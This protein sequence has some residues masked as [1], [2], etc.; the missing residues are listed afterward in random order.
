MPRSPEGQKKIGLDLYGADLDSY[1]ETQTHA[2]VAAL[3]KEGVKF[4]DV[5]IAWWGS[6]HNIASDLKK[7]IEQIAHK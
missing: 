5:T 2:Q 1:P 6:Q 4:Q 3:E 7:M